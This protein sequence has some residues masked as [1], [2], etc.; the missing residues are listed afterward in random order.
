MVESSGEVSAK[1]E[2]DERFT[3]LGANQWAGSYSKR[4]RN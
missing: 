3:L 4:S 1:G 2:L